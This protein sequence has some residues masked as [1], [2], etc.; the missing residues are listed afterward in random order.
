MLEAFGGYRSLNDN[1]WPFFQNSTSRTQNIYNFFKQSSNVLLY[2]EEP[3]LANGGGGLGD[4]GAVQGGASHRVSVCDQG[5]ASEEMS[6][7]GGWEVSLG[8]EAVQR[9]GPSTGDIRLLDI[10]E[11]ATKSTELI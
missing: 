8:G 5:E 2:R 1:F 7:C 4:Q 10:R 3:G 11:S 9:G 6:S